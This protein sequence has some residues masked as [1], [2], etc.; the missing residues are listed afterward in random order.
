MSAASAALALAAVIATVGSPVAHA[1]HDEL[2]PSITG[3]WTALAPGGRTF[4][5]QWQVAVDRPGS[6]GLVKGAFTWRAPSCGALSEPF[7][8][9][10]NGTELSFSVTLRPNVNTVNRDRDCGDGRLLVKLVRKPGAT[11]FEGEATMPSRDT[12][13]TLSGAP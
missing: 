8:G 9:Q 4:V 12:T 10:W 11:A 6:P 1:Q 13:A 3:R 2:P 7:T 5:D